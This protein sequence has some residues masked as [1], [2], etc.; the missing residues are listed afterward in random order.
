LHFTIQRCARRCTTVA[1]LTATARSARTVRATVPR[2]LSMRRYRVVVSATGAQRQITTLR[3][4]L[5]V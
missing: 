4:T 3:R 5:R 2:R 1:R